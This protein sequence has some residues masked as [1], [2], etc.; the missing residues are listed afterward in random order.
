MF[1]DHSDIEEL[2]LLDKDEILEEGGSGRE[3]E[4]KS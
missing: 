1:S 3:M 4:R 2:M